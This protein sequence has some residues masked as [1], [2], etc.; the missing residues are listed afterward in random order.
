MTAPPVFASDNEHLSRV[1]DAH[2]WGPYVTDILDRHG[3]TSTGLDPVTGPGRAYPVFLYGDLLVK[4]FGYTPFWRES[5]VTE[6][7]ALTAVAMDARIG[8]PRLAAAGD[9]APGSWSYLVMNRVRGTAG[10]ARLPFPDQVKVAADLG[11]QVKHLHSRHPPEGLP[12]QPSGA[13]ARSGLPPHLAAQV[14]DYLSRPMP[15]G[16]VFINGDLSSGQVFI[17]DGRLAGLPSWGEATISDRHAEL[18]QVHCGLFRGDRRL[19]R[20]FL[21]AA[22]WPSDKHFARHALLFCLRRRAIALTR[23]PATDLFAP[24]A[25]VL[26]LSDIATLDELATALF[27]A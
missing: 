20:A 1:E 17:E 15:P 14:P 12:T 22:D 9:L 23:R 10:F 3:M 4:L 11:E 19:L 21:D 16:R 13:L 25:E 2:F 7:T 24:I 6:Q 26:P 18:A 5:F 27:D 8:A